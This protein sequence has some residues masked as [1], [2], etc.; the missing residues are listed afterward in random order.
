MKVGPH[1]GLVAKEDLRAPALRPSTDARVLFLQPPFDQRRVLFE[2]AHQWP[3]ACQA[4]LGQ[5]PTYRGHAE[6]DAKPLLD[7]S[8][9]HSPRPEGER[10]LELQGILQR[11]GIVD[12]LHL[13]ATDEA[14]ASGQGLGFERMPPTTA[15]CRQPVVDAGPGKPQRSD[16]NFGAFPSLNLFHGTDSDRL[17]RPMIQLAR[18]AFFH[19]SANMSHV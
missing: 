11:D 12:P 13:S 7:D 1:A 5:Q 14:G 10:E 15:I 18:V 9:D 2:G 19:S 16:D 3:L 4:E 8:L 17:Q 6:P